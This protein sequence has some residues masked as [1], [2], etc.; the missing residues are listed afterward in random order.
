MRVFAGIDPG[1]SGAIVFLTEEGEVFPYATPKIGKE[2]DRQGVIKLLRKVS[3]KHD[4]VAVMEDINSHSAKGRQGAFIMGAG[5]EMWQM[6]L[7]ALEIPYSRVTPQAWQKEVCQGVPVQYVPC[8]TNK[9]GKKKDT[10]ATALLAYKNLFPKVNL[11]ITE[12]GNESKN[13][14]DGMVDALLMAEYC[15]RKNN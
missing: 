8:T 12:K 5:K 6:A 2:Y 1:K 10:K 7:T 14:H 4:L 9:S 3:S 15:R 13:A 11:Y